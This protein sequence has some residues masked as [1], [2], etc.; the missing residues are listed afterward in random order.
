MGL[1]SIYKEDAR[2]APGEEE[3]RPQSAN[4]RRRSSV[5]R[6]RAAVMEPLSLDN[7]IHGIA[8]PPTINPSSLAIEFCAVRRR[9]ISRADRPGSRSLSIPLLNSPVLFF[10][11]Y[12]P[13]CCQGGQVSCVTINFA[14]YPPTYV[15][16]PFLIDHR[17]SCVHNTFSFFNIAQHSTWLCFLRI[18][19]FTYILKK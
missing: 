5:P 3:A 7:L 8:P 2:E 18:K 16:A 12:P 17:K 4:K 1:Y 9:V 15:W 6:T 11:F 19:Y 14:N 13:I 10:A